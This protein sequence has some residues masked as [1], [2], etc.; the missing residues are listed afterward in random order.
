MTPPAPLRSATVTAEEV[1]ARLAALG[2]P[3]RLSGMARYGIATERAFGVSLPE[4]RKLARELGRSHEL[5]DA[6][7]ESGVHEARLLASMVDE[8]A[9]VDDAQMERW[10]AGFASWDLCDQAC[11]NLF[12]R[13][14]LAWAKAQEWTRRDELFVKRAG[15]ALIATLAVHDKASPD[16]RFVALLP[17]I[18]RGADDD[19]PLVRKAASWALRQIGKRS[20]E[21]NAQA[22]ETA[23]ALRDNESRGARW[24]GSDAFR[25]LSSEAVQTRLAAK[26]RRPVT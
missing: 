17:A 3:S 26:T 13:T 7:W 16:E 2:D 8:P 11:I 10:A 1:L 22:V 4:L 12:R 20:V 6:L 9:D 23:S 21:L 14:P 19:R 5:A 25:E 15:F 24:V 18:V